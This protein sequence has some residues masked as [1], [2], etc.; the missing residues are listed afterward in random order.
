M[1]NFNF[2]LNENDRAARRGKITT[3]HGTFETPAFMAVGTAAT[4]KAVK[5]DDVRATGTECILSNTYHL[6]LRPGPERIEMLG[7]LHK[8][9]NWDGPILTDSGGFQAMSL[10]KLSTVSEEGITFRSH[11]DGSKHSLTPEKTIEIQRMLNS[12]ISMV[13]D[14]CTSFPVPKEKAAQSM[15]LSMRW[16]KRSREAFTERKGHALFG[17]IQ[18]GIYLDLREESLAELTSIGFDGYAIGGLAVGEGQQY[19]FSLVEKLGPIMPPER[20]RYLMGVGKPED[21]IGAVKRGID[22]FDCVLPT[23]SGRTNQAFTRMGEVNLR[24]ACHR[25]DSNPLD[26]HCICYTCQNF[27]RAYLHHLA[28]TK[29]I[30]GA[31]LLSQH[32]LHYYQELMCGMRRAIEAKEFSN[33]EAE[34]KSNYIT[35]R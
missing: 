14:E 9:M 24:N 32:N 16:A 3:A 19:M 5:P 21:L 13:L 29:E 17:I 18:G 30:L 20:P 8:F 35:K 25:S 31:V 7:G 10:K 11:I 28:I 4:V 27:C 2:Q 22:M 23:R 34:F 15:R 6:M 12:D 26:P 33:F 1:T